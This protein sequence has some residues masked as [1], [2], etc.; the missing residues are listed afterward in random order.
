MLTKNGNVRF[1]YQREI[2]SESGKSSLKSHHHTNTHTHTPRKIYLEHTHAR[3][4][5][6]DCY[7]TTLTHTLT[8]RNTDT[9]SRVL[10]KT[11]KLAKKQISVSIESS[12]AVRTRVGV[13]HKQ[14]LTQQQNTHSNDHIRNRKCRIMFR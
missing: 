9:R 8:N 13:S 10:A 3:S 12:A 4:N 7:A 1:L 11:S 6:V 2:E 14:T 5:V